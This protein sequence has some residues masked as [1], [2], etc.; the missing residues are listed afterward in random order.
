M[1]DWRFGKA[2]KL[3]GEGK[4]AES[5]KTVEKDLNVQEA[6]YRSAA[7]YTVYARALA[8]EGKGQEAVDAY[9]KIM[10]VMG[11]RISFAAA[12]AIESAKLYEKMDRFSYAAQMYAFAVENYGLTLDKKILAMIKDK[13]DDYAKFSGDPLGW[14]GREMGEV[15]KSLSKGDSGTKTQA[16]Q[17]KIVAVLTDMIKTA[18]ENQPGGGGGGKG[19]PRNRNKK[20]GEGEGEGEGTGEGMAKGRRPNGTNPSAT[21][22]QVSA[23]VGG[24]VKRP[25]AKSETRNTGESGDWSTLP[26]RDLQKI[27][28]IGSRVMSDRY[29]ELISKYRTKV[30]EQK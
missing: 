16:K 1:V 8:A 6:T 29:R 3:L 18:E 25:D 14:A 7:R 23:L 12:A 11:D 20:P 22:A 30:A 26:P 15:G 2:V 19:D 10:G 21:R 27:R 17:E 9:G 5:A 13:A 4:S 24:E 28:S